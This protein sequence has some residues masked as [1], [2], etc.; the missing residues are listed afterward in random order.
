MKLILDTSDRFF[1][2][3]GTLSGTTLACVHF[4]LDVNQSE[5]WQKT[6]IQEM[7]SPQGENIHKV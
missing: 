2:I 6:G 4:R 7:L 5:K 1:K 3:A